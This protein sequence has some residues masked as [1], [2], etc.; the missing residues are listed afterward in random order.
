[1]GL[2]HHKSRQKSQISLEL[3]VVLMTTHLLHGPDGAKA[4]ALAIDKALDRWRSSAAITTD[5]TAVVKEEDGMK[6]DHTSLVLLAMINLSM[7][8]SA[9][10]RRAMNAIEDMV[11]Q[12][13]TPTPTLIGMLAKSVMRNGSKV[14]KARAF[15]L[16]SRSSVNP[17]LLMDDKWDHGSIEKRSKNNRQERKG[18]DQ[19]IH[20]G[21][22]A[23]GELE[24]EGVEVSG[25]TTTTALPVPVLQEAQAEGVEVR[26]A[27]GPASPIFLNY[28]LLASQRKHELTS[29]GN[30]SNVEIGCAVAT[31][32]G[33]SI[34]GV[35]DT[36][37][38]EWMDVLS[39]EE[40]VQAMAELGMGCEAIGVLK[41][42]MEKNGSLI[43]IS[44][45]THRSLL[46]SLSTSSYLL[47]ILTKAQGLSRRKEQRESVSPRKD[48]EWVLRNMA[49]NGY[50]LNNVLLNYCLEA[51]CSAARSPQIKLRGGHGR[52]LLS[53]EAQEFLKEVEVGWGGM[54]HPVK[55]DIVTFNIICKL[56]CLLM[57]FEKAREIIQEV[58][59]SGFKPSV[60]MYNTLIHGLTRANMEAAWEVLVE[61]T[62]LSMRPNSITCGC[63][64]KGYHRMGDVGEAISFSQHAFNQYGCIPDPA[65][66]LLLMEEV[67]AEGDKAEL[68]RAITVAHQLWSDPGKAHPGLAK[69]NFTCFLN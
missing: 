66:F 45:L 6:L 39:L 21:A 68:S 35:E 18:K 60:I 5:S 51:F 3:H 41:R 40:R 28:S 26:D 10:F 16:L 23:E 31:V 63:I 19:R 37:S 65:V 36:C 4:I 49:E 62:N 38:E 29:L 47:S 48:L 8:P 25:G 53:R 55:A 69:E 32:I 24:E 58:K 43:P 20:P 1:M 7:R 56:H 64:V 14:E 61:M 30:P 22:E 34:N 46:K 9:D 13:Y 67:A 50:N 57:D 59:S 12:G 42:A 27:S 11:T 33:K 17:F 54:H 15:R 44:L 2:H 52:N